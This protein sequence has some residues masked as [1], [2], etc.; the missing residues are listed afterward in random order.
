VRAVLAAEAQGELLALGVELGRPGQPHASS[1][2]GLS[3]GV[4]LLCSLAT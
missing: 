1:I 3:A 4:N 2:V